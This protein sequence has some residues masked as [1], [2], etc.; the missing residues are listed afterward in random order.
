MDFSFKPKLNKLKKSLESLRK[1]L[2]DTSD[3]ESQR[4]LTIKLAP[5]LLQKKAQIDEIE[6]S[7]TQSFS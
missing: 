2:S 7:K 1:I 4:Q 5:K 6:K 3:V